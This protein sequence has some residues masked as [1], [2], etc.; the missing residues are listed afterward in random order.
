VGAVRAFI[1]DLSLRGVRVAHQDPIG[2]VGEPCSV[3]AEWD[4][5]PF[6]LK[7]RV[8]RTQVHR[9]ADAKSPRT[10]YHSG[11]EIEAVSASSGTT[12]RALVE[13]HIALAIEE[14]KA[15][16]RG[17]PAVAAQSF[18]TGNSRQF[19]RHELVL[20]RW[21]EVV[22]TDASQPPNGFTVAINHTPQE[23]QMLRSAFEQAGVP[24]NRELIRK[25]AQLSIT[26]GEGIPT[27]KYMP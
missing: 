9:A 14:Q 19:V 22:T 5:I 18:Q 2:N 6:E 15:N 12:L 4:A 27:R 11:L 8:V 24:G 7:C 21:R 25:F 3:R 17:I 1:V 13:H 23:V 16:A 20:G 10:L 26:A